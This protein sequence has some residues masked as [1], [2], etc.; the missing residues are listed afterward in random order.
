MW[1]IDEDNA[2]LVK[3]D[4][5]GGLVFQKFGLDKI[6]GELD[7]ILDIDEEDRKVYIRTTNAVYQYN[8]FGVFEDSWLIEDATVG[9]Q[10]VANGFIVKSDTE[11]RF[12]SF[13]GQVYTQQ[14]NGVFLDFRISH[15]KFFG[16][17]KDGTCVI[18]NFSKESYHKKN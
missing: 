14:I 5:S 13:L 2:A 4:A 18:I 12:Q 10:V 7:S 17:L 1:A 16:I 6:V 15:G 8:E 3:L 9:F 11:I